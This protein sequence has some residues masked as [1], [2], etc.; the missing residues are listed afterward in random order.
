MLVLTLV[1]ILERIATKG[2]VVSRIEGA[3]GTTCSQRTDMLATQ[4]FIG[5]YQLPHVCAQGFFIPSRLRCSHAR[6]LA[7]QYSSE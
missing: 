5:T 2:R 1:L 6:A 4:Y 7:F 3:A